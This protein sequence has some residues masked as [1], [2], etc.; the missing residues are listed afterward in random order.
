RDIAAI[1]DL[2][3]RAPTSSDMWGHI[4]N[5]CGFDAAAQA[6]DTYLQQWRALTLNV[7]ACRNGKAGKEI[8]HKIWA[9]NRELKAE[10]QKLLEGEERFL[11][12]LD[13]LLEDTG[14]Y[15]GWVLEAEEGSRRCDLLQTCMNKASTATKLLPSHPHIL[16]CT[17]LPEG[18]KDRRMI[19]Q[20]QFD[21]CSRMYG[22]TSAMTPLIQEA[23]ALLHQQC[24]PDQV[25]AKLTEIEAIG[26]NICV[27]TWESEVSAIRSE[28]DALQAELDSVGQAAKNAETALDEAITACS[29][30]GIDR[31]VGMVGGH[32]CLRELADEETKQKL[33]RIDFW[34]AAPPMIRE[35]QASVRALLAQAKALADG[36]EPERAL[37]LI[38]QAEKDVSSLREIHPNCDAIVPEINE[39]AALK[40]TATQRA[41]QL[42]EIE[43]KLSARI[44]L[45]E[46]QVKVL[47]DKAA[48]MS[49]VTE[50]AR[51]AVIQ[52]IAELKEIA[53]AAH[54][55]SLSPGCDQRL[56]ARAKRVI[57]MINGIRV[58]DI[59]E[60]PE[61]ISEDEPPSDNDLPPNDGADDNL[62]DFLDDLTEDAVDD[63]DR[64]RQGTRDA[65]DRVGSSVSRVGSEAGSEA[66]GW[67]PP[68]NSDWTTYTGAVNRGRGASGPAYG[69]DGGLI[70]P[71]QPSYPTPTYGGSEDHPHPPSARGG[72][73]G[74][75]EWGVGPR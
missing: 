72:G 53:T 13:G 15:I 4:R 9:Y 30:D 26:A 34:K 27:K 47:R 39:L 51:Q 14:K 12:Q 60:E 48:A 44:L 50:T 52:R 21:D 17:E 70:Q 3:S 25:D 42:K 2:L 43:A 31:A 64:D 66:S 16:W 6:S 33:Q 38:A 75:G 62:D 54:A 73:A 23:R 20:K 61:P 7:A 56:T 68:E 40:A 8:D 32:K 58:P 74:Q 24:K 36:C 63:I 1:N 10:G 19:A 22:D 35:L 29:A 41:A 65:A 59:S 11:K 69:S 71:R 18:T 45:L 5:G 37:D 49:P 46:G 57:D 28:R 55:E 67:S